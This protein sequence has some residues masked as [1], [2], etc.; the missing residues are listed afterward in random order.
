MAAS[1]REIDF[2][3]RKY[4]G[5]SFPLRADNN[6]NFALTK[7]SLQQADHNLRNLLITHLGERI[8][9]PEFGSNLLA[10]CF[11]P[12]NNSLPTS[13]EEEVRRAVSLWLPYINIARVDTLTN[14]GDRNKVFV[15]I[16]YSTT[17]NEE[18]MQ[19]ITLDGTARPS[20]QGG[21]Y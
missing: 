1:A 14:N 21:G 12:N 19:Q 20:E 6:N 5:L 4:V 8:N 16:T 7:N 3:P 13:I 2:D 18:T 9:Q 10:L 11:E 15:S 17:L